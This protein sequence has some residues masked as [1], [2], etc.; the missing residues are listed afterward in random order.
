MTNTNSTPSARETPIVMRWAESLPAGSR[1]WHLAALNP[2][3]QFWGYVHIRTN[4]LNENRSFVGQLD[5]LKYK[6]IRNI[7]DGINP[8]IKD[9]DG[10]NWDGVLGLGTRTKFATLIRFRAGSNQLPNSY[11][12]LEIVSVLH[13]EFM[14]AS[15]LIAG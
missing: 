3:R 10:T 4:E 8:E 6:Q 5:E 15:D 12:F 11:A 9:S 7:L 14:L 2:D 13:P 1:S